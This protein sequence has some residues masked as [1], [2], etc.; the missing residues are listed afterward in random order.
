MLPPLRVFFLNASAADCFCCCCCTYMLDL[1][2]PLPY[3]HRRCG[4]RRCHRLASFFLSFTSAKAVCSNLKDV[5]FMR[6]DEEEEAATTTTSSSS[7]SSSGAATTTTT[8][9]ITTATGGGLEDLLLLPPPKPVSYTVIAQPRSGGT[10][11][12]VMLAQLYGCTELHE[13]VGR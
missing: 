9:T 8:T 13:V 5:L 10:S 2:P 7:S 11:H 3:P 12:V 4:H 6:D 1:C